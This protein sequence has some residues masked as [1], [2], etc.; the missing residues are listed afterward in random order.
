MFLLLIFFSAIGF[1]QTIQ[2]I[3]GET[4]NGASGARAE[5]NAALSGTGNVGYIKNGTWIKFNAIPFT[6]FVSRFDVAASGTIGG[7]IEF[8]LDAAD[9][10]LIGTATVSGST[11]WT[12]YKISSTTITPTTGT[13]DLYLVFKHPSNTGYLFNLDYL[14][15]VTNNPNAVTFT[16]STNVSPAA[17]G[18]ISLNPAGST[19]NQG[20]EI[21]LTANKNFGYHFVRWTDSNGT[22]V[23]TANPYTFTIT[24][25]TTFVAEYAAVDTFTLN[26]NVAGAFGLGEYTVSPAGKDGAFSVYEKGTN[27]TITAVENDIIKFNNWSD[28]ST[29]LSTSVTMTENRSIT[30]TYDN[31]SFIAGWTFKN[32]QYANPRGAELFSNVENKPQLSAYNVTDNVFAPNVRLQNRGG[33]NGFCVWNTIRGDFFYFMTSFSTVGYK[34]INVS[35]GL[36]GYYYGCDEWTFQYSLDGVNFKN[37]SS[38]T[39]INSNSVTP[40]GGIL[41]VEAEGKEKV[42]IRWF[43]NVNGPKHGSATDVTAT[44]LSN[45]IIKAEEVLVSDAVAPILLSSLPANASTTAG[46][47]GNIILNYDEKVKLGTGLA[48]L[49]G[50]N[51]TAE[52]VNKTVKFSYFGLEY[53]KQYTFSLPAGFVT[54]L[55]G[56][57]AAAVSLSFKT[58]EKPVPAKRKFDLI[59]DAN[60]TADQVA[61]GKYVKTIAEAFNKAPSNSSTRFFVLITNGTYNLGGDGTNPQGILLQL[62]SGKNN[63]SLIAQSKDK[64]ILQGNPGQGIKN[65]VLSIEAND[66]YMENITIEHIDGIVN[67]GQKPALSPAGDRNVYNGIR[68][69]SRQDTQV[70]GG[71]RSFYY[72]S[73][74]EG[75]VDFICGG[76]THWFEECKLVSGGGYIVAPNHTADVQYGYVFNNNT[77]T[78]TTS[79]YLGRPWQNAPRAVYLNTTMVN[80]PNTLGWASMG[81]LPALFAEY[82]SVNSN[83]VAVNTANRTNIFTVS[84]VAQTGNYNPVLTKEQATEYTIENVLSG[85]DKW[86]PRSIVEKIGTPSNLSVTEKNTLKWDENQYAIC[87]VVSKD[88]KI[89]ALTT[90]AT[91]IENTTT[92]GTYEY[93]VQAA[94]EYGGLSDVSKINMTIGT[95]AVKSTVLYKN[96]IGNVTLTNLTPIEYTEGTAVALPVPTMQ[97]YTFFGWS[98]SETVPNSIKE[99]STIT[100]GNQIFYAFW[101]TDGNNKADE[102]I[103]PSNFDYDFIAAVNKNWDNAANFNPAVLPVAGKTVSAKIEIETTATVFPADITFSGGGTLRLRGAHKATGNLIFKEGTRVYYNTSGAGMTL[104]APIIVSGN[105]RFEMISGILGETMMTLTGPI[106][107]S[108]TIIPMNIGQGTNANTGTLLLKADNSEFIGTWDLTQKST[109]YPGLEYPIVIEGNVANAFGSGT[110]KVD[111]DNAV[112]FSHE[113]AAGSELKL[114]VAGNGKAVLNTVLNVQKLTINGVVFANGTYDKTSHPAFFTGNGKIQVGENN[115]GGGGTKQVPAFPGAEGYGKYVTGGRGGKVIY[116]TNLNDSGTG[117]LRAAIN[118]S[119]PRIVVFKVSGTIKLESELNITD[120]ITIAGQTAPG[121]GI[122]LRDYNVKVRGNNVIIRYLR[123]RMGDAKNVEND[124]LGG[125]FQKNIIVDH[126]SMSWSTDECVSFYQNENFTLQWCIIS[127]SLRNS[128]HGKGAHGYGGVWGGKNASFHHNLLA[129]H[130]SRNPRLGEYANDP[131]ALTDL[132]DIRNNVIY[133]WGG[134][135]CYG[136]DAMNVNLVNNYWKPGPGTSNSTKERILSTGRSLDTTSPLYGIFGKYFV[137]GNYVVGSTRATQDNWTYG[138]YNQFHGSQLPVSDDQKAA[139]KINAPHNPGEITTHS[140]TKAY[141]LVLEHAGAN[142]FRDAVDLRAVKDTRAGNATIMNGGNGSTNGY[143]DTQTAAGGWPELPTAEA[144]VDTDGDGMPNA[145]ETA[146]GLDPANPTDGNLKTLD[147]GYTNIEVYINSIVKQITDNQ[148]GSLD[149]SVTPETFLEKYNVAEN[150]TKFIM[151][152]GTYSVG[153]VAVTNHNYKFV[154][155][156]ATKPVFAGYFS[157]EKPEV[158]SGSFSFDGIDIDLTNGNPNFIQLKNGASI[159]GLE[160]KNATIKGIKQSLLVTEGNTESAIAAITIDNCIIDGTATNGVNFIQP[161]SYIV[162]LISIKNSTIYNFEKA[163]NFIVLQK[164]DAANQAVTIAVENNTIYNVGSQENNSLIAIDNRYSNAST[165]TFKNNIMQDARENPKAIFMFRSTNAAGVGTAVL[166]HNLLVGVSSQSVKGTVV[167]AET[168]VKT[169]SGLG[170]S[171]LVFPNPTAGDF[172]FSKNAALAT[173]GI[174]GVA[175]GDPRW[176]KTTATFSTITYINAIDGQTITILSPLDY[177]EG[178]IQVLPTPALDGYVFFGWSNSATVPNVIKSIPVTAKGN[179]VFYAFW[180]E[181][182]NNKPI[183]SGPTNYTISYLNL[184]KLVINPNAKTIEIGKAY[185]LLEAQCRGYRFMGWFSDAAYSNEITGFNATQSQ[186]TSVYAR[187]KKLEAFYAYPSV[188]K[189]SVTLKSSIENDTVNVVSV[190]GTVFKQIKTTH[191]ETEISVSDLPMGYYLIQSE[192]S[193]L[194]TKIIVK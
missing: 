71:N 78:A 3:E 15:K 13:H 67:S 122:T 156:E 79:Y 22:P 28:G 193:G 84:G 181:G 151:A 189:Y 141:E 153:A 188:A 115:N 54:D 135:S 83:G 37:V 62:P 190:T 147:E 140:A 57:N 30:G 99:I 166:D 50:K 124:A 23:S 40:I 68:L 164:K 20:T 34:N 86:N 85:T 41:P 119:G 110:I 168:N 58:M 144:P 65:P 89:V 179:Q 2:R 51:L 132:V 18:T 143:I 38:L 63:V 29:A 127:E 59:V 152:S 7:S 47:S 46:A 25:N 192:K 76:G 158:I 126:C 172:S 191:L 185:Q 134:N 105:V 70:T 145:W 69:R 174:G 95:A 173:A 120:N 55:S 184:P 136:G 125:R 5:T 64:V 9:G 137:D 162:N 101:G 92:A 129:H 146:K 121:G 167:V 100:T 150:G 108:G 128:V 49:N 107:G 73:T 44:V 90:E 171:M 177:R 27:V 14:E 175:I 31:S 149:V 52:F 82:N 104:E 21:K 93:S 48:T 1:S 11:G 117:S 94:N 19:F 74:I 176:L 32:D 66:L 170:M 163:N 116:V 77:I 109:K 148:N 157:S 60:A 161:D 6:E 131:F 81:T 61:S 12:D 80:E 36:I 56:N 43:P 88:G 114:N 186:N 102:L 4:F 142:L 103:P 16:L 159:S 187:W 169:L 10:T 106:S 160:I 87:Y 112:V 42:Y 75:D 155:A 96:S 39:T 33:K 138:V 17:S 53:N 98:T 35:S 194:T 72:K 26:V 24:S 182:G 113:R 180:G 165:F 91:F 130:D 45:V 133:N 123:F 97:G 154:A 111:H 8:R 183:A 118:Q 139:L 178:S